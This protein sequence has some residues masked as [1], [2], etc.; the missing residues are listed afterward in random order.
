MKLNIEQLSAKQKFIHFYY[1]HLLAAGLGWQRL[2]R[3][4]F[5]T[6]GAII[7]IGLALAVCLSF[8]VLLKSTYHFKNHLEQTPSITIFPNIDASIED[9]NQ[10]IFDLKSNPMLTNIQVHSAHELIQD[11]VDKSIAQPFWESIPAVITASSAQDL[12]VTTIMQLKDDIQKSP[13]ISAVEFDQIWHSKVTRIIE[14]ISIVTWIVGGVL[15]STVVLM[16]NYSIKLLMEKY[17]QE[18]SVMYHLGASSN[19]IQ[20]PYLYQGL[21]LGIFGSLFALIC[22][23]IPSFFIKDQFLALAEVYEFS[24]VFSLYDLKIIGYILSG[25]ILFSWISSYSSTKKWLKLFELEMN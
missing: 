3:Q 12:P 9:V 14:F 15:V 24:I 1:E 10:M 20:R 18:I 11:L 25:V 5:Q 19:F 4:S 7:L 6:L 22:L 17:K 13:V 16:I 21:F 8:G 2:F 23:A